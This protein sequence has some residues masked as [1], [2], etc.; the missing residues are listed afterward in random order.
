MNFLFITI[1]T[2][3]IGAS[4]D[5]LIVYLIRF[6]TLVYIPK[7]KWPS[8]ALWGNALWIYKITHRCS[9]LQLLYHS[10]QCNYIKQLISY[11]QIFPCAIQNMSREI[12]RTRNIK[13]TLPSPQFFYLRRLERTTSTTLVYISESTKECQVI[14]A[15]LILPISTQ[16]VLTNLLTQ[17]S[18][19]N[20]STPTVCLDIG[21]CPA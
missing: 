14:K 2:I 1:W 10:N 4:K 12:N 7:C 15:N 21:H 13:C 3:S 6:Y 17:Q 5:I 16:S 18:P 19:E 11:S 9:L 20:E 8:I